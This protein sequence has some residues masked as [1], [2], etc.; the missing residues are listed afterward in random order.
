MADN[1]FDQFDGM[2]PASAEGNYFDQFD[3]QEVETGRLVEPEKGFMGRAKDTLAD[4]Q[5]GFQ[6]NVIDATVQ[7]MDT[8]NMD[9]ELLEVFGAPQYGMDERIQSAAS[10]VIST[11]SNLLVDGGMTLVKSLVPDSWEDA[12]V[13]FSRKSW[14][15]IAKSPLMQEGIKY[16][17]LGAKE[18]GEWAE[19]NPEWARKLGEV[20]NIGALGRAPGKVLPKSI[21]DAPKVRGDTFI[22]KQAKEG[23]NNRKAA[24][25]GMLEPATK[26]F[27]HGKYYEAPLKGG[28]RGGEVVWDPNSWTREVIDEVVRVG[29]I[30]PKRSF[31]HNMNAVREKAFGFKNELDELVRTRGRPVDLDDVK[32][33]LQESVDN[34][35]DEVLLGADAEQM[36][37]K[38]YRKAEQLL[39]AS[40]GTAEGILNVRRDLDNWISSQRNVF[41]A[42]FESAATVSMREIRSKLN[43]VVSKN[44]KSAKVDTLLKRQNKLLSAGDML[45]EKVMKQADSRFGRMVQK[46]EEDHGFKFPTTPLAIAA[47]GLAAT[48]VA[49]PAG[50]A[51][52]GST[53]GAYKG[54]RWLMS[55]DG[56]TWLAK[57]VRLTDKYPNMKPEVNALVQISEGLDP[58]EEE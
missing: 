34:M 47:T 26:S 1:Y 2:P 11:G 32:R 13:D 42:N 5:L 35:A 40:D 39:D 23:T 58:D 49:G 20:I 25:Q 7:G 14:E 3:Q 27:H 43:G 33:Q 38:I 6:D 37:G 53:I 51:A 4:A 57:L 12:I 15:T 24:V 45:E 54:A 48:K 50:L 17:K 44:T 16:A 36:A 22:R 28:G 31:V 9:P 55:P 8:S 56:K 52:V 30:N 46:F 29:D 10:E 41:D 18:Y 19:E 21:P